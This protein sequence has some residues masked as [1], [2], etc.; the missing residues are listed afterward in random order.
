MERKAPKPLLETWLPTLGNNLYWPYYYFTYTYTVTI[1]GSPLFRISKSFVA[2]TT[3]S[4]VFSTVALTK[5]CVCGKLG[6]VSSE[7]LLL[8][9]QPEMFF[10]KDN[11][12][13]FV[14]VVF[15]RLHTHNVFRQLKN[16]LLTYLL[17]FSTPKLYFYLFRSD[18][19]HVVEGHFLLL[20]D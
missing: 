17:L 10:F 5:I 6:K 19:E 16:Y 2:P 18:D 20:L 9:Y 11:T 8:P 14:V 7:V 4:S 15:I 12:I 3:T 13:D 1:T